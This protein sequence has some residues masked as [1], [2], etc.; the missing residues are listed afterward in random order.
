MRFLWISLGV[1]FILAVAALVTGSLWMGSYVRSEPFRGLISNATGEVFDAAAVF[2]PLRWNGSSVYSESAGL[3]GAPGSALRR[4]EA[5][6]LRAEVNW[7]AA[8]SGA[9]RVEEISMTRLDGEWG[10]SDKSGAAA[11]PGNMQSPAGLAAL[12]PH[13]FELGLLKIDNANLAFD[14]VRISDSAL[15]VRPDGSGWVFQG[16][17]G[18]LRLPWPPVLGITSFRAREQGGALFLTEGQLRVGE[19]GKITASGESSGGGTL[20]VSWEEVK[21]ADILPEKLRKH[22]DGTLSGN[23]LVS[24]PEQVTGTVRMREGRIENVPL[25]A[26][27]ADFTGNPSFRRMPLQEVNGD[28]LYTGGTLQVKNFSAESKGLMRIEGSAVLEKGGGLNGRFQVGVTPQTLQWLPGSRERV[29][30]QARN[31]YLWTELSV[32]GTVGHPTENL[33]ARLIEAMGVEAIDRGTNLLK[34]APG[35]AT[36]GVRGVLDILRPLVP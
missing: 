29:F 10:P 6:Q 34:D 23:A 5:S 15:S 25:L 16:T 13:R 36:E 7:R 12:L 11:R 9:W 8:F 32:G 20:Q 21:A 4:L 24:F 35:A 28:F 22:L 33:S 14:G 19:N 17:G 3:Q 30:K 18:E 26:T 2:E 31:G 27:V 1:L